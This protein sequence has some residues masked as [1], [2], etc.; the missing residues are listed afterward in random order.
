MINEALIFLKNA[1]NEHLHAK[2]AQATDEMHEDRVVFIDGEK[3]DPISFKMQAVTLLLINIEEENTFRAPDLYR[4]TNQDGSTVKTQP[5]IR[6][7]LYILFVAKFKHYE[8]SLYYI[9]LIIRFFQTNR[10]MDHQNSPALSK[11][12]EKLSLELITLPFGE[13]NEI[14]SALRT[15]YHPSV[16]YKV[17]MLIFTDEDGM[18][19]PEVERKNISIEVIKK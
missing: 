10:I 11:N 7:N 15:T 14:W 3:L 6:L 8:K 17:K 5:A 13:Q 4:K 18:P 16:L 12:I 19:S 2:S 1:L 9:S